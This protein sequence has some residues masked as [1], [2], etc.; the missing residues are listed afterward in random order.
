MADY[1]REAVLDRSN[2]GESLERADLRDLV[3]SQAKLERANLRRA[4]L[5]GVN[6]EESNLREAN[7]S[8]AN[9]RDAYL[10]N[11]DL[12]GA[13]L[14]KADLESANLVGAS[15]KNADLTRANLEGANLEGAN[16]TGARL[17]FAQLEQTNLGGATLERVEFVNADLRDAYLGGANLTNANLKHAHMENANFEEANLTDA[18][19]RNAK[20]RGAKFT[21]TTMTGMKLYG[22]ELDVD[23]LVHVVAEWV[24]FSEFADGREKCSAELFAEQYQQMKN[25][26]GFSAT[27]QSSSDPGKRFFGRGDVLRNA[28]LEFGDKSQVEIESRFENCSISLGSGA[29]LKLGK[30]GVLQGCQIVGFGEIDIEGE[31]RENGEGPGIVGPKRMIVR[32]DGVV[33]GSVQQPPTMTE[34]AFESGCHLQLKI[35]K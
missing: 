31:F 10:A 35:Q 5:E 27:R 7:L 18:D 15:L 25:S 28:A 16:L 11:A 1:S 8:S 33:R 17:T 26:G 12:E 14:Q 6:L 13:N 29:V 32:K 23:R 24:D 9:L 21:G 22:C 3:L 4:D 30:H 2:K 20:L 34:F 19:C